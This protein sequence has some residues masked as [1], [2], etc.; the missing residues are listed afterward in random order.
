MDADETRDPIQS[1]IEAEMATSGILGKSRNGNSPKPADDERSDRSTVLSLQPSEILDLLVHK[2]AA[3]VHAELEVESENRRRRLALA[4]T[5]AGLVGV[6]TLISAVG[7]FIKSAV[8]DE[9]SIAVGKGLNTLEPKIDA[10]VTQRTSVLKKEFEGKADLLALGID[11]LSFDMKNTGF[12]KQEK[13]AALELLSRLEVTPELLSNSSFGIFLE[14]IVDKFSSANLGDELDQIDDR[15]RGAILRSMGLV[16]T[17]VDHY[18]LRVAG[19]PFPQDRLPKE[20]E[21]LSVYATAARQHGMPERAL[22]WQ[23]FTEFKAAGMKPSPITTEL[24]KSAQSLNSEDRAIFLTEL[25]T[26]SRAENWQRRPNDI[27]DRLATI[28]GGL[29][30]AYPALLEL[31]APDEEMEKP[32]KTASEV[33]DLAAKRPAMAD[34]QVAP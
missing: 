26:Y 34:E 14:K 32:E 22:L 25:Q 21:R 27:G 16:Y 10:Q 9:V 15:F 29:T 4:L 1:A 23:L 18:G 33:S 30:A 31:P 6:G 12:S 5:L 2:A 8:I 7:F 13:V 17:F 19:S 28:V 3:K 20:L 24:A 11:A